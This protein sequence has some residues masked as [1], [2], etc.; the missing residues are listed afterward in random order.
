MVPSMDWVVNEPL[1]TI[2]YAGLS[3]VLCGEV[4]TPLLH[5]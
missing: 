1:V 5:V 2:L 4:N 3:A